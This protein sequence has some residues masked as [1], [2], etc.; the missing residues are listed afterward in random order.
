MT[1]VR[2]ITRR[3]AL[4]VTAGAVGASLPLVHVQTAGAAGKLTM[5]IWDHWVPAA[6]PVLKG[7]IDDWAAKN[8]VDVTIDFIASTGNKIVLTQAAEA[9]AGSGHDILAFDQ[10]N[11]QQHASKL[12]PRERRHG[13]ADQAVRASQQGGG[14]SRH[15]RR[16]MVRGAGHVGFGSP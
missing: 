2:R 9:Q 1:R 13:A 14:I 6:N 15:I 10:W 8:K 5:G 12:T 7:L 3:R 11:A 16:K 4:K